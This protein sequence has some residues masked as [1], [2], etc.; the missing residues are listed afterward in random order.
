MAGPGGGGG[1]GSFRGGGGGGSFRGGGGSF[2]GGGYGGHHHHH[3]HRPGFYGPRFGM[4][5]FGPRW[6]RPYYGGSLGGGLMGGLFALIF[7]PLILIFIASI[8]LFSSIGT[9]FKSVAEGGVVQYNERTV[10]DYAK[11]NY[12]ELYGANENNILIIVTVDE[13]REDLPIWL[14]WV[15]DNVGANINL[16]FGGKDSAFG[17]AV[18][19]FIPAEYSNA[20]AGGLSNI[21]LAMEEYVTSKNY[22]SFKFQNSRPD[23]DAPSVL[24]NRSELDINPETVNLALEQFEENTD[25]PIS[26]IV[27][28]DIDVYGKSIPTSAWIT[29]IISV[30]LIGLAIWLFVRNMLD[31]RQAKKNGGNQSGNGFD[32]NQNGDYFGGYQ[33]GAYR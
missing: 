26:I 8:L 25:I 29:V 33:N 16:A 27:A 23:P 19:N 11:E 15:G 32:G 12:A 24:V 3:Y 7:L 9:A 18:D 4:F 30:V 14:P 5:G 22:T 21:V 28:E 17:N 10:Q 31:K 20:F 2:G 6:Y 1:G 13:N